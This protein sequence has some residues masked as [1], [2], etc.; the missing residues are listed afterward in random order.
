[1]PKFD[2]FLRTILWEETLPQNFTPDRPFEIHRLKAR[3]PIEGG[4]MLLIQGVRNIYDTNETKA[5][6]A[7]S[8]EEAK[9]VLIGKAVD[10]APMRES[11]MA[12]LSS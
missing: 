11:L 7:A 12:L 4:R 5:S 2:L 6:S 9:L 8:N 1:M 10:Q 3:I